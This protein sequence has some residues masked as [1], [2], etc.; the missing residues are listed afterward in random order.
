MCI[1]MADVDKTGSF[2][3]LSEIEAVPH[4]LVCLSARPGIPQDES[5]PLWNL[6]RF[7][8]QWGARP[9]TF[10]GAWEH[11]PWRVLGAGLRVAWSARDRLR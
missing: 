6:Y 3:C 11:A 4:P 8:A 5:H 7:K 9:V 1:D 2:E 10:V